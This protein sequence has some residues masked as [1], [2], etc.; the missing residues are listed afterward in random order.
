MLTVILSIALFLGLGVQ[1]EDGSARVTVEWL[2]QDRCQN[3]D[4]PCYFGLVRDAET[5]VV[6]IIEG[7]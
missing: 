1:Y 5:Q 6:T 3:A 4:E 7:P 2:D